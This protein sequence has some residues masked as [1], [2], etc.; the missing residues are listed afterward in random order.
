MAVP[1]RSEEWLRLYN[2]TYKC[3][4]NS[5]QI[6]IPP[7]IDHAPDNERRASLEQRFQL[8][9]GCLGEE[10]MCSHYDFAALLG[11]PCVPIQIGMIVE[12]PA[13]GSSGACPD[14]LLLEEERGRLVPVEMKV[15]GDGAPH[16]DKDFLRSY[17]L[18]KRQ[19]ANAT[20]LLNLGSDQPVTVESL[21]LLAWVVTDAAGEAHLDVAHFVID[22]HRPPLLEDG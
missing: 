12:H 8:L 17:Q 20:R 1:P 2:E 4:R 22:T 9:R 14:L 6:A 16:Q 19:M 13:P 15:V 21:L 7:G 10:L 5:G 3:G 18:A 11:G